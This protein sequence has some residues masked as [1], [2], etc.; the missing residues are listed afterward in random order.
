MQELFPDVEKISEQN[1]RTDVEPDFKNLFKGG[2]NENFSNIIRGIDSGA[3]TLDFFNF[4]QSNVC[5][6]I[7]EDNKLKIH[8]ETGNIYYDNNDTNESI[9]N[10]ILAQT[11]PIS[12][13]I[14]HSFTFDRDYAT[15]F[16][17]L[18]DAFNETKKNKLDILTNKNSKFLFYHFNDYLQQS[19][20]ETIKIKHSV[21][22]QDY[23]A[24]EKIQD[25]NWKYFAES[26]LTFSQNATDKSIEKS[27]LLNTKENVEIL[28][29][30]YEK[31]YNQI[32]KNFTNML[33]KMPFDLF[34]G[35]EDDLIREK[36]GKND[37]RNLD[38]WI[39]FYFKQGRFPG[40][41]DLTILPQTNLPK[42]IDQQSVEVSP[43]ELYKKFGNGNAKSLVSF[44]AVIALFLYYGG[45]TLFAKRAMEEW[46][47]NLTFQALSKENDKV[48]M[49]FNYLAKIV[50]YFL[51]AF[52]TL[53]NEFLE[54]ENLQIE[55][56]NQTIANSEV[57][58]STPK[59]F[60]I[61]RLP[62]PKILTDETNSLNETESLFLKTSFT[63]SKTNLDASIEAAEE[64]NKKVIQDIVDPTPGFVVDEKITDD[65]FLNR[66]YEDESKFKLS[67]ASQ[68]RFDNILKDI[69]HDIR[70][71]KVPNRKYELLNKSDQNSKNFA[72]KKEQDQLE[73]VKSPTTTKISTVKK[74]NQKRSPY[75]LRS[76][77]RKMEY[78]KSADSL[79]E[80]II[81]QSID[82][83]ESNKIKAAETVID[84]IINQLPDRKKLKFNLDSSNDIR[85][86]E[87]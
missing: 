14:D 64:K 4:L 58:T 47:E 51:R 8:I 81:Y 26:I 55:L 69:T 32:S 44:Q 37:L 35:I 62:L 39:S 63:I 54:H 15:Y 84:S 61:P 59:N 43:I 22:T 23:L 33:H 12:G 17:W 46:K 82:D 66:E 68:Q 52:L 34:K 7:L 6:K 19:G 56:A 50:F 9:H 18:T 87:L 83:K 70:S 60:P 24:A 78:L 74:R 41:S 75:N 71:Y 31:L 57:K 20:R 77:K 27:F 28:K 40:N 48:T 21:V 45:D 30:T 86:T 3:D 5:K 38:S 36:Y 67:N 10:F 85:L 25:R 79:R 53:E 2:N 16:D 80:P 76:F 1:K 65:D 29:K 13:E 49:Q 42:L 11:N 73:I 72:F